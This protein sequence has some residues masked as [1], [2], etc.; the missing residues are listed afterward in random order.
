MPHRT[1]WKPSASASVQHQV[2]SE[3]AV[4]MT[5]LTGCCLCGRKLQKVLEPVAQKTILPWFVAAPVVTAAPKPMPASAAA[6]G[7][8]AADGVSSTTA[9]ASGGGA[10]GS[11]A[12]SAG[13]STTSNVAASGK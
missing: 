5:A 10:A 13:D 4:L 11:G 7:A 1:A 2:P 8:A 3:A 9:A 6:A 12:S